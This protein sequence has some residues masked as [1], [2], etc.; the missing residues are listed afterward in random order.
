[1][2]EHTPLQDKL[3]A[4]AL[5]PRRLEQAMGDLKPAYSEGGAVAEANRCLYCYDAPCINACPTHINI[6]EFIRRIASGN[7][8]GAAKTILEANILGLSCARVCPV[9]VLCEGDCVYNALGET[10]IHIGKLQRFA[11]DHAYA[12][13]TRFFTRGQDTGKQ[14]ALIGGGPASLSCA[15]ELS[16]LGHRCTIFESRGFLGGLNTTGIAAYKMHADIGLREAEYILEIGG[17]DVKMG[18]V[19]GRDVTFAELESHYD[20][21]FI[22]VGLGP[23]SRLAIPGEDLA[24]CMGAV[25][26]IDLIKTADSFS[27]PECR[28]A[29]VVGGGNTA[30]DAV[31]EL[32]KL[33]VPEVTMVYRRSEEEMP[34]YEHEMAWAKK[35]S[36]RFQFLAQPVA[37]VGDDQVQALRCVRMALGEPDESGRR[38]PV[39]QQGSDFD[40]PADLV[41]KA[42]GQEKLASLLADVSGLKVEKGRVVVDPATHQ[43]THPKYFAGGDCVN[44]G[45]EVVNAAAEGKVAAHGIDKLVRAAIAV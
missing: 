17:I 11:T 16:R 40:I 27:L 18:V 38:R 5:P 13:N 29:V 7:Y 1:M 44:G 26:L 34:G 20:A 25:E 9:E 32:K 36:V 10:P 33:G 28:R 37:V 35:E 14:I 19:V 30:L 3:A 6:P 41:V 45:K 4:G 15:H 2:S 22:G 39:P 8:K 42:A 21:I 43:T 12:R 24:G 23:D 31:R